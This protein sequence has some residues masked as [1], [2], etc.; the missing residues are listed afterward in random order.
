MSPSLHTVLSIVVA[1]AAI[2]VVASQCRRP[3]SP[4][5][6]MIANSMNVRHAGVTRWGLSHVTIGPAFTI[7]DVGCGGGRTVR[8]LAGMA[9]QGH[10][11]GIDYSAASVATARTENAELIG[12]GRVE[13]QSGTVSKLPF[14]D[15]TFDLVT[16]VET[17]YYW[18]DLVRD[19][20]EIRR[21][22]KPGG[23]L[24][25]IAETF[26]GQTLSFLVAIP[27]KLL[28]AKYMTLER[29]RELLSQAGFE[30]IEIDHH[31]LKGWMCAVGRAPAR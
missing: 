18:P 23:T 15:A 25:V 21:V 9:P 27:M 5:G 4:L 17:H 14:P 1:S 29:H 16:A 7:L 8:T 10:V 31:K 3:W 11:D 30:K 2:I 20:G 28:G 22:L 13:I 19:L 26:R 6:R 12:N 24:V